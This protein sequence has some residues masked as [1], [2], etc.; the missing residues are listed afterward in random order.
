[1]HEAI[2]FTPW[3]LNNAD[4]L[5]SALGIDLELTAAEH[6]VGGFSLDL[7]GR[8]LTNNCVLIVENQLAGT[9]HAHLGQLITYAAGTEAGTI[10]WVA[11]S[12]REE[13]RQALDFLNDLAGRDARLFAVQMW[14]VRIGPS[15][16]APLFE[17]RA[18]PNDWHAV[19]A[20]G[21]RTTSELAGKPQLYVA[22]WTRFLERLARERPTWS[23]ARKP[24]AANWIAMPSPFKGL[25]YYSASF[26]QGGK[27]RSELYRC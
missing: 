19:V 8:D 10:V 11:S 7:I 12:F 20:A 26:A 24:Q 14:A 2:D 4:A 9:D 18:Q 16:A 27:P 5:G 21:A 15:P 13:H 25:S 6:P 17:L 23:R 3:L 1:M 22:F